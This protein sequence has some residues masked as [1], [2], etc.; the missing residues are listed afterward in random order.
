MRSGGS[1][2]SHASGRT[3][4]ACGSSDRCAIDSSLLLA[5]YLS[6][7]A[8]FG[9][10][11]CPVAVITSLVARRCSH[12]AWHRLHP[13]VRSAQSM[14]KTK[15]V[16]HRPVLGRCFDRPSRDR[17]PTSDSKSPCR[18]RHADAK[19]Q[20]RVAAGRDRCCVPDHLVSLAVERNAARSA[21]ARVAN[22]R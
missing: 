3:S 19:G 20:I 8:W 9:G 2:N 4:N 7:S 5:I 10:S 15:P 16:E 11:K 18:V 22:T 6:G 14:P 12:P 21:S 1:E 13:V 17:F